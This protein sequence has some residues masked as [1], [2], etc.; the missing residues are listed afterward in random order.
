[1]AQPTLKPQLRSRRTAFGDALAAR[2]DDPGVRI[3]AERDAVTPMR[4]ILSRHGLEMA[5]AVR[6]G[7]G[8]L[9]PTWYEAPELWIKRWGNSESAIVMKSDGQG[10]CELRFLM[11]LA[12]DEVKTTMRLGD[13]KAASLPLLRAAWDLGIRRL[14]GEIGTADRAAVITDDRKAITA[15]LGDLVALT[16]VDTDKGTEQTHVL[17]RRP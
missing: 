13:A 3:I 12:R 2:L 16:F 10:P 17:T 4:Q 14:T 1:V 11:R 8:R 5:Q 7:D 15:A 6:Q 9:T